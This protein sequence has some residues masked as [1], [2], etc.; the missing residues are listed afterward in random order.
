MFFLI[1]M[2]F[3]LTVILALVPIFFSGDDPKA[4]A[5]AT[6]FSAGDA[7]SAATA[8]MSDLGQF[9]TRRP[10]ACA[11]GAQAASAIG[12]S[13][14]A[15]IR[16]LYGYL[17]EKVS[18]TS[19]AVAHDDKAATAR[20]PARQVSDKSADKTPTGSASVQASQDTLLPV[21]LAPTWRGP[22]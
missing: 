13:A 1:R 20:K 10:E 21:D 19:T 22:A 2:A 14:Q 3:W 11:V 6:K 15:G 18:E 5:A 8:T 16:I 7:V 9:C 4:N 12:A 17:Q